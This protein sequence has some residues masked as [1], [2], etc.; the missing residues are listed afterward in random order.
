MD[1][2]Q[3]NNLTAGMSFPPVLAGSMSYSKLNFILNPCSET[4]HV[5]YTSNHRWATISIPSIPPITFEACSNWG[6]RREAYQQEKVH[7]FITQLKLIEQQ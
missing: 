6:K 7:T 4:W 1:E 3:S 2:Q 5:P